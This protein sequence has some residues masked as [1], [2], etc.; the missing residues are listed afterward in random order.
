MRPAAVS[1]TV[2]VMGLL[3]ST[4]EKPVE[5][6]TVPAS[7]EPVLNC[8]STRRELRFGWLDPADAAPAPH[9]RPVA[10]CLAVFNLPD[11]ATPEDQRA[12]REAEAG[13]L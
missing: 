2:L 12:W 8:G 10:V 3:A 4:R 6:R 11:E 5:A 13:G 9:T 1:A 7:A